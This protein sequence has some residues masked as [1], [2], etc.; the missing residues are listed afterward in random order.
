MSPSLFLP[1]NWRNMDRNSLFVIKYLS[2]LFIFQPMSVLLSLTLVSKL[3]TPEE[4]SSE[5]EVINALLLSDSDFEI[6]EGSSDVC[7]MFS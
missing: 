1:L 5:F 7:P 6:A 4:E 3:T 2:D